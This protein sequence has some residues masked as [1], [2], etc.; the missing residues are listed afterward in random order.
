MSQ[1]PSPPATR[2]ELESALLP[3]LQLTLLSQG[4]SLKDASPQVIFAL[5]KVILATI[6][7]MGWDLIPATV[8][9]TMFDAWEAAVPADWETQQEF[10]SVDETNHRWANANLAAFLEGSRRLDEQET[11]DN[12]AR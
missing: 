8:T 9:P 10:W 6:H 11:A 7:S 12:C 1:P 4:A 5:Q 2:Q 3:A